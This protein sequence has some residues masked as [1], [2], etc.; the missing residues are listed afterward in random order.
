MYIQGVNK[1]VRSVYN[2]LSLGRFS[3]AGFLM[4]SVIDFFIK[5]SK[6]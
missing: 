6:T 5:K 2:L 4:I 3:V 1:Y